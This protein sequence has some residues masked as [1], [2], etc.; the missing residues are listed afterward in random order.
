MAHY[1]KD[2]HGAVTPQTDEHGNIIRQ[3][4]QTGLV[5][6]IKEHIP[7]MGHKDDSKPQH[8]TGTG[9]TTTAHG[10][11][12][13][14]EQIKEGLPGMGH[15]DDKT[16][17]PPGTTTTTTAPGGAGIGEKIKENIPG[18]GHKDD[19]PHHTTGAGA[20][21]G[22]GATTTPGGGCFG[23][24]GEGQPKHDKNG[25]EK[26]GITEKIKEKLPGHHDH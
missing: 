19:K 9:A 26:K 10:G 15:R 12:G 17:Y 24:S 14:G 18:M 1:N 16:H 21:A 8:H 11:G 20:G 7:G 2:Q 22:A 13:L 23:T 6:Q 3:S 25:Q 4:G 5:E